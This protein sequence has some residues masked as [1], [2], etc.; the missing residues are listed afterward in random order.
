MNEKKS[1]KPWHIPIEQIFIDLNTG[2]EGLSSQEVKKKLKKF[3]ANKLSE[4]KRETLLHVFIRQFQSPLIYILLIAATIIFFIGHRLDGFIVVGVLLFNAFIGTI[5]EGRA[6][7]I[8]ESLRRFIKADSMVMR[9]GEGT[10]IPD[11]QLVVGD[12][13]MVQAGER[14]PADARIIEARDLIINEALL[15]GESAGLKKNAEVLAADLPIYKQKNMLFKGTYVLSGF[16]TAVVVA[17]GER[18]EVGKLHKTIEEVSV[19]MPIQKDLATLSRWI[20]IGVFGICLSL[21]LFGLLTGR[22]FHDLLIILTALFICVVPEGLPV[23]LTLTL[24]SGA[25]RMAKQNVL[26]KRFQA[27]EALGRVDT[28]V[29]DKTGTLTRNEMMVQK[30]YVDNQVIEVSGKGYDESGELIAQNKKIE[31]VEDIDGLHL[32]AV[33]GALLSNAEVA[34]DRK[35][36]LFTVKGDPTEAALHILAHK[37][38]IDPIEIKQQYELIYAIP[39]NSVHGFQAGFFI[40]DNEGYLFVMG[41]PEFVLE[42]SLNDFSKVNDL[43]EQFLSEGLRVIALGYKKLSVEELKNIKNENKDYLRM[44]SDLT[45]LGLCGL[46]DAIREGVGELI[47][48]VRNTYMHVIMATG[49]HRDTALYVAKKVGIFQ[50]GDELIEGAQFATMKQ[51]ELDKQIERVTVFSRVLPQYKLKIIEALHARGNMVAMTGDGVNDVPSMVVAD[52]GIAMGKIG[53]EVT[54]QAADMILLDDSFGS[55]VDG[56]E[57]G[58]HVFYTLK[59]VVLYFF[60]TN[61]GEIL[62]IMS[63]LFAQLPIPLF[64]PQILWLNLV[65]DGFLD[66]SLTLEPK[67]KDLLKRGPV[68]RNVKLFDKK[69]LIKMLYM[70]VP[71][72]IGSLVVFIYYSSIDLNL[73]RTMT[74]GTMA[75]FQWFNAWNCRSETDSIFKIGLLSNRWLVVATLFVFSLQVLIIYNPLMQKIF[76]TVPLSLNQWLLLMLVASSILII[77]EFR[78]YIVNKRT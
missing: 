6:Q 4:P 62:L 27:V 19:E 54:K 73:A 75:L 58:R 65:T 17:T 14:I 78:K 32:L 49:D 51:K 8:L 72:A 63:A 16:G 43:L 11:E 29:I 13:I 61:I 48:Q 41:K 68:G 15:T 56:I 57:E 55:I 23:A 47:H 69:L 46:Q 40:H 50:K 39:F 28:L 53:T 67:E 45:F 52:V 24:V 26:V 33:A 2:P 71:M 31:C 5:Q 76:K 18:T 38:L 12:I 20:L 7:S 36:K 64:A 21:F 77:E 37:L 9:D 34:Y 70:G 74:L 3:G 42:K 44:I 66:I 22:S 60:A 10:V 1:A 59:R 35:E 30:I 25:Y